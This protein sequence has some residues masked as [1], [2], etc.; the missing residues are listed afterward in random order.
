MNF[1]AWATISVSL[2]ELYKTKKF[3]GFFLTSGSI[4]LRIYQTI[5]A[6]YD[7]FNLLRNSDRVQKDY[8]GF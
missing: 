6:A 5:V 1:F 4:R 7:S 3:K 2:E 8:E